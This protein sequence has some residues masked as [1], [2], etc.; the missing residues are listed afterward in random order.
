MTHELENCIYQKSF[1]ILFCFYILFLGFQS[2]SNKYIL[3]EL[4]LTLGPCSLMI[5]FDLKL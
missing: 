1:Y 4:F 2:P 3:Q 5:N